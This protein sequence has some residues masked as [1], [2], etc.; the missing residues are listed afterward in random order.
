MGDQ[1]SQH[2]Y[3]GS[4]HSGHGPGVYAQPAAA[5]APRNG[6]AVAA[7]VLGIV[8]LVIGWIPIIGFAG[9]VC[10]LIGA[11]LGL[12]AARKRYGRAMAIIGT[13]LSI[14][15]VIVSLVVWNALAAGASAIGAGSPGLSPATPVGP[16]NGAPRSD[17]A[18]G[19]TADL[20]GLQM[21]VEELDKVG[22]LG[23]PYLCTQVTYV[24]QTGQE[25]PY[26]MADWKLQDP[27][28]G[29]KTATITGNNE[30]L[31]AGGVASGGRA[32]GRVCF[33]DPKLRGDYTVINEANM[34]TKEQV[35]WRGTL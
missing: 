24:N 23:G 34:F 8:A 7:L 18:I 19:E 17:F 25:Q 27:K 3:R 2:D 1:V 20:D 9:F 29:I 6:M 32:S 14:I 21:T 5:P 30:D 35:R 33:D 22:G 13:A 12:I 16:G 31:V 15:G 11:V 26:N 4:G 28:G 10:G